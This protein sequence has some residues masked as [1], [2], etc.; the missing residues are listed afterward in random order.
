MTLGTTDD[1]VNTGDQLILVEGLG[2]VVVGAEAQ[3]ADLVFDAGHTRENQD[4]GLHL[5]KTQR[6]QD[7]IAGHIRQVEVEKDDVIVIKFAEIDAFFTEV[8]GVDIETL[9]LE[10]QLNALSRCTIVFD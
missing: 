5:G 9:G 2:H 4:R 6:S 7:F 3:A 10:H 8:G 1:G